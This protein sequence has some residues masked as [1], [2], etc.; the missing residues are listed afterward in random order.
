MTLISD[1]LLIAGALGAAFYCHVLAR[2]LRRFTDLEKGV[3]GAVAVL[4]AQVDDLTRALTKAQATAAD[5][6]RSLD[7]VT[8]R[9]ESAATRIELLLASL[10]D[11]PDPKAHAVAPSDPAFMRVEAG[12]QR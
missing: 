5:S 3:G 9:A 10:H 2:R 12:G 1:I 6:V 4:S 7:Q 8:R 11:L